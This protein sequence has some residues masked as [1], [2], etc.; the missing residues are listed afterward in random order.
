MS[1]IKKTCLVTEYEYL[2]GGKYILPKHGMMTF[3]HPFV[4]TAFVEK[5][6]LFSI[7]PIFNWILL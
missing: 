5:L 2:R 6:Y 4:G 1:Y 7:I 3:F